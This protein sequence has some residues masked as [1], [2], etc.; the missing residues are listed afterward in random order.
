MKIQ[1]LSISYSDALNS[2]ILSLQKGRLPP[3]LKTVY[4]I[5]RMFVNRVWKIRSKKHRHVIDWQGGEYIKCKVLYK[6]Q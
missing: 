5:K 3:W 2:H 6:Q 4:Y 1:Q